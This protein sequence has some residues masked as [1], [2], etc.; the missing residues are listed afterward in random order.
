[1]ELYGIRGVAFEL[2]SS[3]LVER[4]QRTVIDHESK[5][6]VSTYFSNTCTVKQGIPQGSILGPM[7]FI[8]YVLDIPTRNNM[9]TVSYAD[10]TSAVVWAET[11]EGLVW[12]CENGL[13]C[14]NDYF[15][16]ENLKINYSKTHV[17]KFSLKD[18]SSNF[19]FSVQEET[20]HGANTCDFLGVIMDNTLNWAMHADHV[21]SKL[22]S[23]IYLLRRMVSFLNVKSMMTIY[24]AVIYPHLSYCVEVWG[25]APNY[26]LQRIFRMQ[27]WALRIIF[28][29]GQR[30]SCKSVFRD[31]KIL[32]FYGI[33]ILKNILFV[34]ENN[35][36][37]LQ[38]M[39][40]HS[41]NTRRRT[42]FHISKAKP[43]M[44]KSPFVLGQLFYNK[45]PRELKVLKGKSFKNALKA[46]LCGRCL[47]NVRDF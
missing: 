37:T 3:F 14:L 34:I 28:K 31:N 25:V 30:E 5:S 47:Y 39:D 22:S 6:R 44:T 4:R 21:C 35:K 29:L 10:D 36:L 27:K 33:L 26:C 11:D 45:L 32:T 20:L 41:H 15:L 1:M 16:C 23:G 43:C 13:D 19:V 46:Y 7:L 18:K 42:D 9:Q 8:L 38:N 17:L 2:I 40:I 12:N 24:Y